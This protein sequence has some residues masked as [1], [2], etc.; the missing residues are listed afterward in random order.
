MITV[1]D[2]RPAGIGGRASTAAPSSS[3]G[4][5]WTIE[6]TAA[7]ELPKFGVFTPTISA[8][9]GSQ[10]GD[11]DVNKFN[12]GQATYV[13]ANGKDSYYYWNAGVS[14]AFDKLTLDFRYWDT[15]VHNANPVTGTSNFCNGRVFQCDERFV[16]TA[17]ITY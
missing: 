10:Y 13:Q 5:T 4:A 11:F 2:L 15:N 8:L 17:K 14:L 16:F 12:A 6:S 3:S 9:L 1:S 7:Y